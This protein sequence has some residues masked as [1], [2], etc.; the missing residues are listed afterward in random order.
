[1]NKKEKIKSCSGIL[2]LSLIFLSVPLFAYSEAFEQNEKGV[3]ESEA[4]NFDAAIS[5]FEKALSIEPENEVFK[6]NLAI[7]YNNLAMDF[8]RRGD[9]PWAHFHMKQAYLLTPD[10]T[11]LKSNLAF[12]LTKEAGKM[13]KE[14]TKPEKILELLYEALEYDDSNASIYVLMGEIYYEDDRQLKAAKS[15][16][17]AVAINPS[18]KNVKKKLKKLEREIDTEKDFRTQ[19]FRHFK[20]KFEGFKHWSAAWEAL[21]ILDDAYYE[22]GGK[23]YI[24]PDKPLTTIIYTMEEFN[25]VSGTSDWIAGLYDGKIRIKQADIEGQREELKRIIYHEYI[26]ALI[27]YFVGTN[28]PAW[29]NEGIAQY[30][31]NLPE[32]QELTA[33][34]KSILKKR[35]DIWWR[36]DFNRIDNFFVSKESQEDVYFAYAFSKSFVLYLAKKEGEYSF[37][38]LLEK[39]KNGSGMEEAFS[40]VY[41][42]PVDMLVDDWLRNF[43]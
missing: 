24:F 2:I 3:K 42:K 6:N 17:K 7:A 29:L 22:V 43:R 19:E 11:Q 33:S 26:H 5:H 40:Q 12:V 18:L 32:P 25:T 21:D 38:T 4:E 30:Y 14:K 8:D 34:E 37:K 31:E 13:Y 20:V 1:M 23:F 9:F 39:F 35:I 15:W 41:Y 36:P 27:H 28:I 10:S 16:N